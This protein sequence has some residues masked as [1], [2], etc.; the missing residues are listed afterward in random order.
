MNTAQLSRMIENLIR[1]GQIEEIDLSGKCCRVRTGQLLTNWLPW[2]QQRAGTT[3]TWSP[4]TI[5]EQVM[6]FSPSGELGAGIV[7]TGLFSTANP[8]PSESSDEHI[9]DY[10]DGARIAYNHATHTL[11]ATGIQTALV[12][13]SMQVTIDCPAVH[14]TGD[15]TV[16]GDVIASEISLVNHVHGG[17][18]PGGDNTGAPQ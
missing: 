11:T 2:I 12:H 1:I 15:V 17:I 4:P 10:P 16:D 6:V 3:R 8:A 5:G 18:L 13:A 14:F 7:L 9:T